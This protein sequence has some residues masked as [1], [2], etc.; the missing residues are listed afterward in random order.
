MN[1]THKNSKWNKM[2]L[3]KRESC[4][5]WGMFTRGIQTS[6]VKCAVLKKFLLLK[7]M[8]YL[9]DLQLNKL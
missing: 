1:F 9:N 8:H 6:F 4:F 2:K 5:H 3:V 7:I